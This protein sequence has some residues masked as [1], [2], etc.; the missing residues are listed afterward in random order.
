VYP[1]A[2][3]FAAIAAPIVPPAPPRFSITN[4]W[5]SICESLAVSGRATVSVPPPGGN[6][7]ITLTGLLG[8]SC[9]S[10][11]MPASIISA[12]ATRAAFVVFIWGRPE[13]R[14]KVQHNRAA[15]AVATRGRGPLVD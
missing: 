8:Q 1:S 13:S 3:A 10:A 11:G 12:N 15:R 2:G 14:S 7:T 4:C 9:A 5:P 6:G